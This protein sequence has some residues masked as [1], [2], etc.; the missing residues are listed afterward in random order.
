MSAARYHRRTDD[1]TAISSIY[2]TNRSM[3]VNTFFPLYQLS[4][5]PIYSIAPRHPAQF[6]FVCKRFLFACL[7]AVDIVLHKVMLAVVQTPN[8]PFH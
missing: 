1:D 6:S 2:S 4:S 3:V 8:R 5:I 7:A